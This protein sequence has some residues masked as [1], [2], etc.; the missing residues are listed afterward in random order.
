[1]NKLA[2][3]LI[4]V[5][6]ALALSCGGQK[7]S[8]LAISVVPNKPVVN[9]TTNS[10]TAGASPGISLTGP[11]VLF[12]YITLSWSGTDVFNLLSLQVSLS[13]GS[14]LNCSY[15]SGSN[16]SAIFPDSSP[17]GLVTMNPPATGSTPTTYTSGIW[18]CGSVPVPSPFP[19]SGVSMPATVKVVGVTIDKNDPTKTTGRVTATAAITLQ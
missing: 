13:S 17:T 18:G 15:S 2:C 5:T 3:L 19:D 1:M 6:M 12:S 7:N 4:L 9:P 11:L 8:G 16:F 14:T 10:I